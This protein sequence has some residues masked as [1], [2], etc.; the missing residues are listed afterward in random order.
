MRPFLMRRKKEEVAKDLPERI[1]QVVF[2]EMEPPQRKIYDEFLA[3]FKSNLL[4]KIELEGIGKHRIAVLEVILRL[5][6]IC[7]HP[8][9]I[10]GQL[11]ENTDA[12]SS[13]LDA[14]MQDLETAVDEGRKVLVYSQ[15][16][17]MLQLISKEVRNRQWEFVYLDGQTKDREKPVRTFQEDP[18]TLLFLISLKAGGIGLNLTAADYVFLYDPWW[19]EAVENQAI[20]R[21]HRIG[22]KDTV[23]AK[24]YV[25]IE[26]IEEKMMNLK[27]AKRGLLA[28]ILQDQPAI[29]KLSIDDLHYLID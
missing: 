16:T 21:A 19:N 9:L 20:D 29:E 12:S 11:E 10:S 13:K 14:L 1:E 2:V 7:C 28:D 26:T 25:A 4:K 23:I 6:Q 8:L 3:S 15:F 5:R 27:A 18:N 24:R 17:S 22:R